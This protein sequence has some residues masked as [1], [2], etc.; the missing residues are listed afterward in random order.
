MQRRVEPEI[1]DSLQPD[2]PEAVRNRRELRLVNRIMGNAAWFIRG[3]EKHVGR[4][5]RVLELGAGTG[6]LARQLQAAGY[7]VDGLDLWPRPKAWPE[8]RA[9]HRADLCTFDQFASYPVVIANLIL[10]QFV[11]S[12]LARLGARIAPHARVVLASEPARRRG[13]Q[14]LYGAA[15]QLGG[16]GSVSR[17]DGWVSIRAG[18][19]GDELP[20][21]LG[22]TAPKWK[23]RCTTTF[24]AYRMIAVKS[25]HD[26]GNESHTP[27][28]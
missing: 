17:H 28:P 3:F 14:L 18:F 27:S 11:D 23:T 24:G 15:A 9:W 12:D 2:H 1:L 8:S 19:R 20:L 4:G 5:E 21:R 25:E 10:H 16:V 6:E 26:A 22:L 7:T 13:I